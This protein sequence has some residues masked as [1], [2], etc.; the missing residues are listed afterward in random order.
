MDCEES[1]IRD[2]F[3]E[4]E[5]VGG[6]ETGAGEDFLEDRDVDEWLEKALN[7]EGRFRSEP[8]RLRD[9]DFG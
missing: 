5:D 6:E 3:K 1:F 2:G 4:M 8:N 9:P 7:I